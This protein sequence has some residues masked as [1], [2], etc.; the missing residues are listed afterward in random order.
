M[1]GNSRKRASL[2]TAGVLAASV[3]ALGG[4]GFVATAA[5]AHTEGDVGTMTRQVGCGSLNPSELANAWHG[6]N[7]IGGLCF[8]DG[9]TWNSSVGRNV[10]SYCAG[11]HDSLIQYKLPNDPYM[12]SQTAPRRTCRPFDYNA[13][14]WVI[15]RT[16]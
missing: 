16:R 5:T 15:T 2:R 8:V 4:S 14:I 10:H 6:T 11:D 7:S 1:T 9:G 12:Y 13:D 3:A